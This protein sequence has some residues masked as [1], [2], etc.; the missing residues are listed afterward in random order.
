MDRLDIKDTWEKVN[1]NSY[2]KALESTAYYRQPDGGY[3]RLSGPDRLQFLQRQT[4]NDVNKL[5]QGLT[6]TTVLTSPT[7]RILDVL[8][9]LMEQQNQ[10]VIALITLPGYSGTTLQFL[11][12]RI[13]FMDQVT[14]VDESTDFVQIDLIGPAWDDLLPRIGIGQPPSL[15]DIQYGQIKST[16]V[17]AFNHSGLGFRLLIPSSGEP[18]VRDTLARYGSE[19]LSYETY[20]VLRVEA[21]FP[22]A[23]HEL[24]GDYTPLET[25]L[26]KFISTDKGCYTGQEVLARQINYDK[27]TRQLVGL[28]LTSQ[29]DVGDRIWFQDERKAIGEITSTVNSPRFGHIALAVLKRPYH[30]PGTELIVGDI[31]KGHPAKVADLPF[32]T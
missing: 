18:I 7:A 2:Q 31:E 11:R 17:L 27:I 32:Q 24:T 6:L 15:N 16:P 22:S 9:I 25:G 8:T 23:K 19:A 26:M 3:L 1:L 21:G 13:F 28:K 30:Q 4:T 12:S 10:D 20:H 14:I 5:L 29:A